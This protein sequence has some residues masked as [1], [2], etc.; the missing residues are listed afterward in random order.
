[1]GR[2]AGSGD[3][4]PESASTR[5]QSVVDHR[6]GRAMGRDHVHLVRNVESFQD[7]DGAVHDLVVR[8]TAHDDPHHW[9]HYVS[10]VLVP[11]ARA[12]SHAVTWALRPSSPTTVTWPS[13]R[14]GRHALP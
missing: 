5:L 3:Q 13:L 11:Y 1:M 12:L 2:A 6:L 14:P 7:R 8:S 9:L 4:D 10:R